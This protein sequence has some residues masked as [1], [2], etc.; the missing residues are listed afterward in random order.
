MTVA[1]IR[2]FDHGYPSAR[3]NFLGFGLGAQ[4]MA[5]A[6]RRIQTETNRR[7][8]VGR[9]TG[10]EPFVLGPVEAVGIGRLSAADAQFVESVHTDNSGNRGDLGSTGHVSFFVNGASQV[11]KILQLTIFF[12]FIISSHIV[13]K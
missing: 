13:I 12:N 8:I 10:L 2:L 6:S 1:H 4:I 7:H 11:H 3:M 9:L 5:R